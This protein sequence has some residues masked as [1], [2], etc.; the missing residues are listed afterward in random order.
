MMEV[1]ALV[2]KAVPSE[3]FMDEGGHLCGFWRRGWLGPH[4]LQWRRQ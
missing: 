2:A 1:V 3:R 4:W